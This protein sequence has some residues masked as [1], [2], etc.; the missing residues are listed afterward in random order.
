VL[1]HGLDEFSHH[2]NACPVAAVDDNVPLSAVLR[3][4]FGEVIDE[5]TFLDG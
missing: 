4:F 5:V 2:E 1:N 3:E